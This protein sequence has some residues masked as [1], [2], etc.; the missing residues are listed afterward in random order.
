MTALQEVPQPAR[1]L[2]ICA[3]CGDEWESPHPLDRCDQVQAMGE[4]CRAC[5]DWLW[6]F[7]LADK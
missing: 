5:G 2:L 3:G 4:G 6:L 1:V 7:E